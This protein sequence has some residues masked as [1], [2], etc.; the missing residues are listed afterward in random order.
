M[1][2]IH[3]ETQIAAPLEVVFDL[4]RDSDFHAQTVPNS[5]E[6]ATGSRDGRRAGP[7]DVLTFTA[8]HF[9]IRQRLV[10]RRSSAPPS[11]RT[12]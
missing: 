9:G 8:T 7:E 10:S 2:V 11:S 1:P 6:A 3:L 4:A 12:K 5:Q